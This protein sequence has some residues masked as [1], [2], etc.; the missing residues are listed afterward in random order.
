MTSEQSTHEG[1]Y[2]CPPDLRSKPPCEAAPAGTR[3]AAPPRPPRGAPEGWPR[4]SARRRRDGWSGTGRSRGQGRGGAAGGGAHC[5]RPRRR[6][7][8]APHRGGRG[9]HGRAAAWGGAQGRPS[10]PARR[11][12]QPWARGRPWARAWGW[13]WLR[14]QSRPLRGERWSTGG[15]RRSVSDGHDWRADR[16]GGQGR[17]RGAGCRGTT[18]SRRWVGP[19]GRRPAGTTS[20][21]A[22]RPP[23]RN[24][25][26]AAAAAGAPAGLKGERGVEA[27]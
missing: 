3:R 14:C 19:A 5:R 18:F 4:R 9:G 2:V 13:G 6:T 11:R 17:P 21:W 10:W 16:Q 7:L 24:L 20:R 12:R 15:R 22:G 26:W 23:S 8:R 27:D 25:P 1:P